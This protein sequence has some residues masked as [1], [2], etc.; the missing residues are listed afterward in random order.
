MTLAISVEKTQSDSSKLLSR[1]RETRVFSFRGVHVFMGT[2]QASVYDILPPTTAFIG[3]DILPPTTAFIGYDILPPTTAL[4][5][6]DILPPTTALIGYAILPPTTALIGYAILP[7]TTAFIGYAIGL[8]K[9]SANEV[10][11]WCSNGSKFRT[12]QKTQIIK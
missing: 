4:I 2:L 7:P 5:G 12:I 9:L 6:Y 3:Y 11:R 8:Q 10:F 1:V